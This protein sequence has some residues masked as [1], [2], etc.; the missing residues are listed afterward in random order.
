MKWL[1]VVLTVLVISTMA[2]GP[3]LADSMTCDMTMGNMTTIQSLIDCVN[4][5][6]SMGHVS[7]PAVAQALLAQLN[8][9]QAAQAQGNTGAAINLL[10]AFISLVRAQ[11]GQHI[12]ATYATHVI[13][14]AQTVIQALGD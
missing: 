4:H 8:A 13:M 3:A 5:A 2:A 7:D 11:S 10:N 12:T 14:H 6:I 1:W 9:A